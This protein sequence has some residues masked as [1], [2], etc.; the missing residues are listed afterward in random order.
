MPFRTLASVFGIA[1]A[2]ML[3]G[4]ALGCVQSQTTRKWHGL[5]LLLTAQACSFTSHSPCMKPEPWLVLLYGFGRVERCEAWSY[6]VLGTPSAIILA[7]RSGYMGFACSCLCGAVVAGEPSDFTTETTFSMLVVVAALAVHP[8]LR[9]L[10]NSKL[11]LCLVYKLN[12]QACTA[13]C[14]LDCTP[15]RQSDP[16]PAVRQ[17]LALHWVSIC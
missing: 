4:I 5:W 14:I 8:M 16:L 12:M 3:W 17:S 11:R 10:F 7:D 2:I 6:S 15:G 13:R 1:V 9:A